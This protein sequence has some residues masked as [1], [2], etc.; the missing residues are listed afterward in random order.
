MNF[1][2]DIIEESLEDKSVLKDVK[3]LKTR[4]STVTSQY[5]TPWLKHWTLHTVEVPEDKV[6][7]VAKKL[8]VCIDDNHKS[9][10]YIDFKNDRLHYIIFRNKVFK[11]NLS[12]KDPYGDAIKYGI[13]LGIP[14]SQLDFDSGVL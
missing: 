9:S 11:V 3:V 14:D 4:V 12:K 7:S 10:W 2:G 1:H 5:K 6:E 13:S 8:S